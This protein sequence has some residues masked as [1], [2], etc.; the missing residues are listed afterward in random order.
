MLF[1]AQA[2]IHRFKP[3]D[4]MELSMS[5]DISRMCRASLADPTRVVSEGDRQQGWRPDTNVSQVCVI[6]GNI[7][8]APAMQTKEKESIEIRNAEHTAADQLR[9]VNSTRIPPSVSVSYCAT[10]LPVNNFMT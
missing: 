10:T 8:T 9:V 4:Q 2:P 1:C 5:G 3:A 6:M 7:Q